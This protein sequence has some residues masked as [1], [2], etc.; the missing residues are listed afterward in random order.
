[1]L[2]AFVGL[3]KGS[4][5][6]NLICNSV[7]HRATNQKYTPPRDREQLQGIADLNS[8]SYDIPSMFYEVTS[9]TGFGDQA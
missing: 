5:A 9:Q 2:P 4:P 7:A 3:T 8:M 1:M 6:F